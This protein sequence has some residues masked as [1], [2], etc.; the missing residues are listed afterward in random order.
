MGYCCFL[1]QL[2][3]RSSTFIVSEAAKVLGKHELS[4]SYKE[5]SES[6]RN[7]IEQEYFTPSGS[8]VVLI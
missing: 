5:L 7:A 1:Q 8:N 6:V 2:I 4:Q 3:T